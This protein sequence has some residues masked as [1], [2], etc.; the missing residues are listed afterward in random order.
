[1]AA[2][3][4][5]T[6]QIALIIFAILLVVF[7]A[8]TYYFY[9]QSSDTNQQLAAMK[10]ERDE[11][12]RKVGN[13]QSDKEELLVALGFEQFA[14]QQTVRDKIDEDLDRMAGTMPK[15]KRNY[16]DALQ[17]VYQENQQLAASQGVDKEKMNDL[18]VKLLE[19]EKG[20]Q[21]QI[22]RLETDKKQIEQE[23]AAA[24]NQFTKARAELD[25]NQ[26]ALAEQL[27]KQTTAFD[28]ERTQLVQ[29]RDDAESE[30]RQRQKTIDRLKELRKEEEF[31]FE[32]A[33]GKITWVNQ[34]NNTVWIDI[35]SS[36]ALRKQVTFSVYDSENTDA[37][38]AEKKG[39][40][41]VVRLL[42]ENMAECRVMD[43]DPRNPILPGD[44]IYSPAWHQGRPQHF[45][46][47]GLIDLDGDG[48]NDLQLAKDL[49]QLN[50]GVVDAAPNP[51][52]GEQ[53]GEMTIETR[54]MVYGERSEKTN[55]A[56]LRKTWDDMH[57]RANALG[58]ELISM[59]DFVNQMGYRREDRSV[60]LGTGANERDFRPRPAP[61]RG[62]LR[63]RSDYS[64]Q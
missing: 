51:E 5:Q 53:E 4:D 42:G 44:Y 52:T 22:A 17:L 18:E 10:S 55:E 54:Y 23:A 50:G 21:A 45:A 48:R 28:Q 24:R 1:M 2:R 37:G 12:R 15:E 33:D 27:A 63:P 6:L 39:A 49:I 64:T 29:A 47:T 9:K 13:L 57:D 25:A 59:T 20:H 30:I 46:L 14:D 34:A 8:F 3:Q 19:V 26:K 31:S 58:V 43:D 62:D 11:E 40:V 35:G 60:T 61:A 7:A 56:A 36:D 41:E 16:R 32:I 38:K